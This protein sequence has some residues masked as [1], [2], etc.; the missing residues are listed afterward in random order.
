MSLLKYKA[1]ITDVDGTLITRD[2]EA[3]P[4]KEVLKAIKR[5]SKLVHISV[6]TSRPLYMLNGIFKVLNLS[7]PQVINGGAQV[8]DALTKEILWKKVISEKDFL[9]AVKVLQSFDLQF[10]IQEG[11][12]KDV[13]YYLQYK[14]DE[15]VLQ[16]AAVGLEE[17]LARKVR[18]KLKPISSLAVHITP[19]WRVGRV[20]LIITHADATKQYG[21]FEVAKLL[22]IDTKEMIGVG[23]GYNDFPL[24]MACGLKVAMGDAP[25]DLKAIADFI[26]PTA[27]E[28]GLVEVIHKFIL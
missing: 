5:A 26:A 20:A 16:M 12:P 8:V 9:K 18:R 1:L 7:G 13:Y 28:D 22:G 23:D 3:L 24:L 19:D 4:S 25:D 11:Q 6:A 2:L 27:Q 17:D 21:V 10:F 15:K 14:P